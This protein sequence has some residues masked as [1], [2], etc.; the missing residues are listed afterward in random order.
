MSVSRRLKLAQASYLNTWELRP[1]R[2][3][4]RSGLAPDFFDDFDQPRKLDPLIG[5]GEVV[6][7]RGRGEA[8][9]VG[10]RALAQRDVFRC[11]VDA[12]LD[13]VLRLRLRPLRAHEA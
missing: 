6:A 10:E 12:A 5:L 7:V 13:V 2:E 1:R 3:A 4:K 11:L 8:A 9:L